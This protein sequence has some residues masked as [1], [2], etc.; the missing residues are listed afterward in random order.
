MVLGDVKKAQEQ[1]QKLRALDPAMAD[2][3][4]SVIARHQR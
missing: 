3:L 1:Q 4:G 2:H